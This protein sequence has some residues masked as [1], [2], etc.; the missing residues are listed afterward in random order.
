[1]KKISMHNHYEKK[2]CFAIGLAT[3]NLIASNICNSPYLYIVNAIRQ[4]VKVAIHSIYGATH[5]NSI[6]TLSQ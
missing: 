4:V 6:A 3:K 2:G 1:M 5:Y